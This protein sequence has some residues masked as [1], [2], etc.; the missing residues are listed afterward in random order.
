MEFVF[1]RMIAEEEEMKS[2]WEVT[3]PIRFKGKRALF[4]EDTDPND[5]GGWGK[6]LANMWDFEKFRFCAN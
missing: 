4:P 6:L 1:I 5:D 3:S 2:L